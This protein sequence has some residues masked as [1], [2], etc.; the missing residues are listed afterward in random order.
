MVIIKE[1][2]WNYVCEKDKVYN[3]KHSGIEYLYN[4]VF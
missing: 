3:I 4:Y 2:T 1:Y